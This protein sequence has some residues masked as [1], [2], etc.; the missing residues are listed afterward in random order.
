MTHPT[1]PHLDDSHD[2]GLVHSHGWASEPAMPPSQHRQPQV[3]AAHAVP[4]PSTAYQDD[5]R[6]H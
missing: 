3:A 6:A 2:D 5:R 4:T 1:A